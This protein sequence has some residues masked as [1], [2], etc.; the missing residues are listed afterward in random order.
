VL[1]ILR[2]GGL[3]LADAVPAFEVLQD[4]VVTMTLVDAGRAR[5]DLAAWRA[6]YASLPAATFPNL[7]AA[8]DTLYANP[9][10]RF[11]LGLLFLVDGIV[12]RAAA[13]RT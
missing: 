6:P 10:E 11:E 13:R 2:E 1:A 8:A 7:T 4:Y 3:S 9:E 5:E 12:A